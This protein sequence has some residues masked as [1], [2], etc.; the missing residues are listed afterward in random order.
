MIDFHAHLLSGIDDGSKNIKMSA[1]MLT[2]SKRQGIEISVATPHFYFDKKTE[3]ILA[4][5]EKALKKLICYAEK[6]K[7]EIPEI[8]LG[9]EVYLSE[10]IYDEPDVDR[11]LIKGTNTMLVEMP[12]KKWDDEVFSRLEFVAENGYKIV[13]AH[14]ERYM[15]VAGK[16]EYDRLF[17]YGFAGQVNAASLINPT[18]RDFAYKLIKDGKIKL[19]GSDAHNLGTRA[20]FINIACDLIRENIGEKYLDMMKDNA[21]YYLKKD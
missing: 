11:L 6:N 5:R 21:R 14:P 12:R 8:I 1:A 19:I 3:K 15:T 7:I 4:K 17:S 20:N 9:F 13:L 2:E 10:K 16:K 18:T